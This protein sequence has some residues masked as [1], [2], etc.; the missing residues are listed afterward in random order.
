MA[1]PTELSPG[2]VVC[3]VP[4]P[5][6]PQ[7]QRAGDAG[8]SALLSFAMCSAGSSSPSLP[9]CT[10]VNCLVHLP[11]VGLPSQHSP[12]RNRGSWFA[13][14][15]HKSK[16]KERERREEIYSFQL[17]L[18]YA[19]DKIRWFHLEWA[20]GEAEVAEEERYILVQKHSVVPGISCGSS[21]ECLPAHYPVKN[22][23]FPYHDA[24]CFLWMLSRAWLLFYPR[25]QK[26]LHL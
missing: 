5:A 15:C 17:S 20:G 6:V 7:Q 11:A 26:T 22:S 23:W 19:A 13:A 18:A 21:H 25:V 24:C 10:G 4:C 1:A 14:L 16:K 2:V 3:L 9:A 12:S 8:T